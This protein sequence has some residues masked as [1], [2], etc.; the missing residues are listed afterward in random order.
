MAQS[1]GCRTCGKKATTWYECLSCGT[2]GCN[3]CWSANKS[4]C[5]QCGAGGK[6]PVKK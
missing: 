1:D 5:P 6:K 3:A 4:R 2:K